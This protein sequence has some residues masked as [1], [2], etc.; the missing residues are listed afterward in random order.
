MLW[1]AI[2][3]GAVFVLSFW[4]SAGMGKAS[5]SSL[6]GLFAGLIAFAGLMAAYL[7]GLAI[8]LRATLRSFV[9]TYLPQLLEQLL[10]ILEQV[11]PLRETI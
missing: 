10:L 3:F 4:L 5:R 7:A 11:A 2:G 9:E 6:V 8:W 1:V